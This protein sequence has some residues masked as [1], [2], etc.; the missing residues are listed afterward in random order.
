MAKNQALEKLL[1]SGCD[2]LFVSEYDV[3]PQSPEAITGYIRACE[4]SG[5]EHLMF[6]AHGYHNP[7]PLSVGNAVTLWPNYV[8][9][10]SIYS[11][12]CLQ[13]CG[14]FDEHFVTP[15]SM[16]STPSGSRW[17][18]AVAG[19]VRIAAPRP[20]PAAACAQHGPRR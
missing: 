20:P 1:A 6:H 19:S 16:S 15:G 7:Q 9:A 12:R 2:W 11:S 18:M 4:L 5:Y 10:W 17:A 14:L 13:E 8:G 3:L